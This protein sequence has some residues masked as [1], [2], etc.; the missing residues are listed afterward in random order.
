[1]SEANPQRTT[2]NARA[3]KGRPPSASNPPENTEKMMKAAMICVLGTA[4]TVVAQSSCVEDVNADGAVEC[5]RRLLVVV[6]PQASRQLRSSRRRDL[7]SA[8]LPAV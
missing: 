4:T 6:G 2:H 7:T 3:I 8:L 5:V 1:M